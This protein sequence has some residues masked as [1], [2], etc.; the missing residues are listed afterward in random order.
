[1]RA[2]RN[3][4]TPGPALALPA[5]MRK[6]I[7]IIGAGIAGLCTGVYARRAGFQVDIYEAEGGPGG[8]AT[9]WKRGDYT[10]ETCLHWLLGSNPRSSFHQLWREVFDI[11]QLQFID[12]EEFTRVESEHGETLVVYRDP[13]RLE[14]ELLRVAPEDSVAIHR[15]LQGIRKLGALEFPLASDGP[16][17]YSLQIL[18]SVPLLPELHHWA[19]LSLAELSEQFENPL[20]RT[21]FRGGSQSQM[22]A[23]A[24]VLSL[25]WMGKKDAGYP[26]G[27]SQAIIRAIE[28]RF[29]ELGG[30]VHYR[31]RVKR[32][33]V[34][35]AEAYGIEL[36]DGREIR[37][38]WVIS[39]ADGFSTLF[40][41]LPAEYLDPKAVA[42]YQEL[43][44]F[45]SYLQ[46]SLGIRR[47]MNSEPIYFT[48][49][50]NKPLTIDPQTQAHEL[51]FRVFH[52][53]P[54][55]A[56]PGKTPVTCFIP[57][58]NT[59][60]WLDLHRHDLETYQKRKHQIAEGVIAAL[61]RRIP[62]ISADIEV[63]DV[64]TPVSV[65]RHTGNWQGSMEGF[66]LTPPA[67]LHKLPNRLPELSH[68]MM[69]G[70]WVMPGGGLPSGLMTSREAIRHVCHQEGHKFD[71]PAAT[72]PRGSA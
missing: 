24:L 69:T 58:Y 60:Y 22:S 36:E 51:S 65:V 12:S 56:P 8:L 3:A 71:M 9:S 72:Y 27:G 18:K 26:I 23:A 6:R 5:G 19:R 33:L 66:L 45:P 21:F 43:E 39:A 38:D 35:Q 63:V 7:A 48:R 68:F 44:V 57:T 34:D 52:F 42:P 40:D 20:L 67:N 17:R 14:R 10:F 61:E 28:H 53:D 2:R 16:L 1:M 15:V 31:S 62:G 37:A 13:D 25:S 54:S 4:D 59:D 50:L 55:F 11:D 32:I 70:Q 64:S 41:W 30:H 47:A 46:V 49:L 29:R